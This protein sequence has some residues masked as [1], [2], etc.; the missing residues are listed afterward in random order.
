MSPTANLPESEN[1]TPK[2]PDR[3]LPF[4]HN[5]QQII[6]PAPTSHHTHNRTQAR[7]PYHQHNHHTKQDLSTWLQQARCYIPPN[8][9]P[10]IA[11]TTVTHILPQYQPLINPDPTNE[12][13]GDPCTTDTIPSNFRVLSRNVN[14]LSPA[15]D[16]LEWRSAAQAITDYSITVA[17]FQ[18]TNLQWSTPITN[19][20]KQIFRDLPTQQTKIAVSNSTEITTSNFQPGGTCTTLLGPWVRAARI[21]GNDP[22]NMGRWSYIEL[23]G[24]EARRIVIVTGYRSCSQQTRLGSSTFHD[25][26]YR[27]MLHNGNLTPDPRTQFIDDII[28][29]IREW[30]QQKKAVLVCLDANENVTNPNPTTGIGRITAETD[31]VDLHYYKYPTQPRPPTYNRG[32]TTIDICLGSPEF[33]D[34]L[35]TTSILPFGLPV[36]L[37][38][39][40]RA[41]ILD[42]DSRILFGHEPPP[43]RHVYQR[44][45]RS[46]ALPTVTKFSK[47][48]GE[49]C[50]QAS[51]NER[52]TDM[53]HLPGLTEI[54]KQLLNAIDNELTK[55]LVTADRKC[56]RF[57]AYPW[58]PAMHTTYLE[59]RYWALR[60]SEVK[61]ERSYKQ[62]YEKI[63]QHLTKAQTTLEFQ[64]TISQRLRKVRQQLRII[65]REAQA[66]RKEF[67]DTLL[68]AAKATKNKDRKKLILGL[69]RAEETRR[70]F[71]TVR[72]LLNPN[73]PGGLTHLLVPTTDNPSTWHTIHD[74]AE[75][76][77]HLLER[78]RVHFRQAH[79]TPFT[80]PPLSELLSTCGTNAFADQ[81]FQGL[82]IPPNLD[83]DPATRLLLQNQKSL[84]LPGERTA[85]PLDFE[86]LMKGFRKWPERTTTSPSGRHLGVYK[87]LLK[88]LPPTNPPPNIEP[89]TYGIDVMRYIYR[90]LQLAVKHTH[91]YERWSVVWNMYLEKLPGHPAI[92][93]LRTL[94]LFEADYNLLLKWFS[95]LGFLP[96]SEKAG[97]LHDSQG[98]GRPGR[99]AIDLAC[100]KLVLYDYIH[101]TRSTAID[102]SKDVAKCF[103]RMIEAC[104]NLSCRQHGADPNYLKLHAAMQQQFK[105][106]VKHAAGIS[107]EYNQHNQQDPWYGAGQ[108]A[109]D[110]CLRWVVQANSIILAY[111][112]KAHSWC[113]TTP[114]RD[115]HYQ[116]VI[117][118]FIDDTD[119]FSVQAQYQTFYDLLGTIQGNLDLW[120][121]LLQASGG[122]LNPD[123]CVW[124]CFYW[125][126]LP[127]GVVK[128][129][130]PPPD[131]QPLTT[132][133]QQQQP[134]PIR[135][136]E[137]TEAHR[138]LGVYLT[139]DGNHNKEYQMFQQR[140]NNYT[141]LLQQCPFSQADIR[142][143]Y[144]QCYLPTVSYPLPATSIPP[145]KLYK[146]QGKVTSLFLTKLGYP[147]SFPR[148]IA[149]A[150]TDRGGIGMRHL[151]EEQGLQKILQLL[152]HLRTKTGIGQVYSIVLQHYQLMS[153]L[154]HPVLEDTR[155][156]PWST[157][158]WFDTARQYLH[159]I[160]GKVILERPWKVHP[161]RQHDRYIMDDILGLR[162]PKSQSIQLQSVRLY[163]HITLLSELVNHCG[164]Q[165]QAHLLQRPNLR[166]QRSFDNQ[167]STLQW[168]HQTLPGPAAWK[169]WKLVL[170]TLYLIPETS[171]LLNPLG[172]WTSHRDT[173]YH[174]DWQICPRTQILFSHI[175]GNWL[176]YTQL[177]C[178][179]QLLTFRRQ[180]SITSAP[181]HTVPVTPVI[182]SRHI[183]I[184]LPIYDRIQPVPINHVSIPLASRIT[185]PLHT[186]AE[187]LWH[188]V[189][190]LAHTD[191]L[192]HMLANTTRIVI[193]SDAAVQNNGNAT[194]AWTIWANYDLW[195]G[196]GY[197]P[198]PSNDM[199]SGLAEAYGIYTALSF[200]LQYSC[201][202][203]LVFRSPRTINV[204]CDNSGVIDRLNKTTNQPYPRDA[205][206]DD[207]PIYAEI[208]FIIDRLYPILPKLYHVKGHQDQKPN[209]I[210]TLPEQLNV[211]CDRRAATLPPYPDPQQLQNHPLNTAGYPHLQISQ[212]VITRNLQTTLRDAATRDT[213]FDYLQNKF[214]WSLEPNIAVHWQLLKIALPRFNHTE[215]KTI[216]KFSHE[217]LP[218]QDR[219]HVK[220]ASA[221]HFCPSCQQ[222]QETVQHFL[223]CPHPTRQVVWKELHQ[224]ILKYSTTHMIS[225]QL[226]DLIAYGLYHGRQA[227]PPFAISISNPNL[228][229]IFD[230]QQQLGW[231]QLY[232][233]R[234]TPTW[235]TTCTTLHP[236]V[237]GNHFFAQVLTLVWR[238]VLQVWTI[239]N[240]HLHPNNQTILDRSQ[241]QATVNQIFHDVRQD[242]N[243]QDLLTYTTPEIVMTKN[244]RYIRQWVTNCHNHLNNQRKAAKLRAKLRTHDI[245]RYF[246][247]IP[248]PPNATATDKN[249]L[250]PP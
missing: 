172:L 51:L 233:G 46:N 28:Q 245:R 248:R 4:I 202:Y 123:K 247:S 214:E 107:Q 250:R 14:S 165:V 23:E 199:Y 162:L 215:K 85:Q 145:A 203:P 227:E 237:N 182:T 207:Y 56:Q 49:A 104:T 10:V 29:Q 212:Q 61:T 183:Q 193:V 229:K 55:I 103:D 30:R 37:S 40:H 80:R 217:W 197:V 228:Q 108:G 48:V 79:G 143:I 173:D 243:L 3:S 31:L 17:C 213:Y 75:M 35:L 36:Y 160:Q 53:E 244:T 246:H 176:A 66:K 188:N 116:Q 6:R 240:Q 105:Y 18:E 114:N 20:I 9:N 119:L 232:Y 190:P 201:C 127:N 54:D 43:A 161:R 150:N 218:L 249:L 87:S 15:D 156:I 194:C 154:Q 141:K 179:P 60:F 62:A 102:L 69:K 235:A 209:R 242:P 125:K 180:G 52:I 5:Q 230:E 185:T 205:I 147:R 88:D 27:I 167:R 134:A 211:D 128:I 57:N 149:Y 44:G 187:P 138:Y 71:S 38:G 64:E 184:Q 90:L 133:I 115:T 144:K 234:L 47:L 153:G 192:R 118:A 19:R 168:P 231:Q 175:D 93:Q 16:F 158:P 59:H 98:G 39:D 26:Q 200:L 22:T 89:R 163:L 155:T 186:W 76:E 84:L 77:R 171:K 101:I 86:L 148:A 137:P 78:S 110:A 70:C 94:H 106:F 42:F 132:T 81:I 174:W 67:L 45:A 8:N 157:T 25:Q 74:P 92:D 159:R 126:F 109:G 100:K 24:K 219:Y 239:R 151:G 181:T 129:Q 68:Q 210:L 2:T 223:T 222:S 7:N 83:I 216:I 32:T 225:T 131:T 82:P 113:L 73:T 111:A 135:R 41:L 95:S 34:A 33:V 120:H 208:Q 169:R 139:T 177:Q 166:Y 152:K 146:A 65:R 164:T 21:S 122:V 130:T 13:W 72:Q 189:R 117:D 50:D 241:L 11:P 124:L 226:Q 195:T 224:Q 140:N 63:E 236:T 136:L 238:A 97:R 58:T 1:T 121:N 196:E 178:T 112:S 204:Y 91:T 142:V 170:T 99:S 191:T 198:G 221:D 220:S 96:K 206:Y 12:H